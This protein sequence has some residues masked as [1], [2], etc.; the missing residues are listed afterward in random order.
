MNE[1]VTSLIIIG[2]G[3]D[4]QCKLP[5]SFAEY[6]KSQHDSL[7]TSIGD[8][9][10][11]FEKARNIQTRITYSS[12]E[13][14][15][16]E[17]QERYLCLSD[18]ANFWLVLLIIKMIN[19][20]NPNWCDIEK[21]I[22][23]FFTATPISI[24]QVEDYVK[25]LKTKK[26]NSD[27]CIFDDKKDAMYDFTGIVLYLLLKISSKC[28]EFLVSPFLFLQ[29][30]L[31]KL[32]NDFAE[33]LR[34]SLNNEEI[35]KRYQF[36][37]ITLLG[38]LAA[39]EYVNVLNFNYTQP[40]ILDQDTK[41][42]AGSSSIK[43]EKRI[44]H[45]HGDLKNDDIIL[46]IDSKDIAVNSD[47]YDFTK[48]HRQLSLHGIYSEN[49]L[50]PDTINKIIF[51]GHSLN[52]QDYS[53][54]QAIFDRYDIYESNVTLIFCYTI[55]D[56]AEKDNIIKRQQMLISKLIDKYSK[57]LTNKAHGSNLFHKL[58]LEERIVL[59]SIEPIV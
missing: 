16:G 50:L 36:D 2:N 41:D 19:N 1:E 24:T 42:Q 54:F 20:P 23:D 31:K 4:K 47:I 12:E 58:L 18:D 56:E 30:E 51:Y 45:V 3:F 9:Y 53:Y 32:E 46:G 55:Y 17:F 8:A 44:V 11:K 52:D 40:V 59:R 35:N 57:T 39:S 14:M 15:L 7:L 38:R 29:S 25:E 5:S 28:D 34:I 37:A 6:V 21:T 49:K 10:Q 48:T 27:F 33:Y 43:G 13:G 26:S 22:Y